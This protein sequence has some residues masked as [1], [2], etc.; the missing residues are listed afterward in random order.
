MILS[1]NP[2]KLDTKMW[3]TTDSQIGV[4]S[5]GTN[6]FIILQTW[7]NISVLDHDDKWPKENCGFLLF[8][9]DFDYDGKKNYSLP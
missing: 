3:T 4:T 5:S 1:I 6:G 2:Y 8:L 7:G 9:S